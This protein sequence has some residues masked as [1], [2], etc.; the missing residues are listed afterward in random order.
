[1]WRMADNPRFQSPFYPYEKVQSGYN[2]MRGSEKIP[3]KLLNY[4][5]DL[6]D[7]A[8]YMP[9]DDNERPRVRL[10]KYLWHDGANPLGQPLPTPQQKLSLLFDGDNPVVDTDEMKAKHPKGYRLYPQKLWLPSQTVAKTVLKCY[11]GRITHADEMH[12]SLGVAFEVWCNTNIQNNTRGDDYERA[13]DIEQC[14]MEALHGV[15]IAGIGVIDCGRYTN[16]E[17]GSREIYDETGTNV[18]RRI[19]MSVSWCESDGQEVSAWCD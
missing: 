12:S 3:K 10:M 9:V 11:M 17:N 14:L 1:M 13:Y 5:L 4:L 2:S 8:G 15:N 7:K 16:L 19:H 18:G 6:P